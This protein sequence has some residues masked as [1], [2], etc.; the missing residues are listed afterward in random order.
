M[1]TLPMIF[2]Q[3]MWALRL[4]ALHITILIYNFI[5]HYGIPRWF[6]S[7]HMYWEVILW[8]DSINNK[9]YNDLS[10]ISISYFSIDWQEFK[11]QY[12]ERRIPFWS[13]ESIAINST[14]NLHD[15]DDNEE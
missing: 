6:I 8:N 15:D 13:T 14:S 7:A 2:V 5:P 4:L 11:S 1:D 9:K 3:F 10:Q 12:I